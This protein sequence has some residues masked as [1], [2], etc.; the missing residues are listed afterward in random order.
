MSQLFIPLKG[1]KARLGGLLKQEPHSVHSRTLTE[2]PGSDRP[3]TNICRKNERWVS[4]TVLLYKLPMQL[5]AF[6]AR[7][8]ILERNVELVSM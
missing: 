5:N 4:R 6:F 8:V 3:S 1:L 2:G 7:D